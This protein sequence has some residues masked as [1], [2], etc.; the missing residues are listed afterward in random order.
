[1]RDDG[2]M[3]S[4]P[5]NHLYLWDGMLLYLMQ[6]QHHNDWHSHYAAS[7]II[8]P[9]QSFTLETR[10]QSQQCQLALLPPNTENRIDV[11][12]RLLVVMIDADSA[13]YAPLTTLTRDNVWTLAD[14]SA[15][16]KIS[17]TINKLFAQAPEPAEAE[18]T[19]HD[20]IEALSGTRPEPQ[21]HTLDT[22]IQHVLTRIR[23][24]LPEEIPAETLAEEHGLS[25]SRLL[26]LFKEQLGLPMGQ[27]LLW[28]RLYESVR[29]WG[30]GMSMTEAA[31]AAGFYDQ[32]HYTRTMRRMLDVTPSQVARNASL[33]IHHCWRDEA[34][35]QY[36][37]G[38]TE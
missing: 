27:Y 14:L 10:H 33:N 25:K 12:G 9:D 18:R 3:T 22:R 20:I 24:A 13:T 30:E 21:R 5:D 38:M 28:R 32:P 34:L 1:M 36:Q 2:A 29:L 31:H 4:A 11:E 7:L 16:G 26:H 19:V 15:H 23:D 6:G 35:D 8:C 37:P 17:T